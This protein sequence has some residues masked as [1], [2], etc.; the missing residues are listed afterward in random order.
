MV[1]SLFVQCLSEHTLS[2]YKLRECSPY[3]PHS[4]LHRMNELRLHRTSRLTDRARILY[5]IKLSKTGASMWSCSGLKL[6]QLT[7]WGTTSTSIH[8]LRWCGGDWISSGTGKP[9]CWA[10][11]DVPHKPRNGYDHCALTPQQL[12]P[13]LPVITRSAVYMLYQ[14][15]HIQE[16]LNQELYCG[17]SQWTSPFSAPLNNLCLV[18]SQ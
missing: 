16:Y 4:S 1:H 13:L 17:Y 6:N 11:V 7:E 15:N 10:P 18:I 9:D 5:L 3:N 14:T 2:I 8:W 12:P